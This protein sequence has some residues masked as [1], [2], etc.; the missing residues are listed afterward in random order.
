MTKVSSHS[1]H[2]VAYVLKRY[3]RYSETFVVNEIL[4]HEAAGLEI[5]IFALRPPTDPYFQPAISQV[6]APVAYLCDE[7][8]RADALWSELHQL[9]SD[10]PRTWN[11]LNACG[12]ASGIEVYQAARLARELRDRRIEHIHAHFA[13]TAA[14]VARM[15][16]LF[17]GVPYTFTAHAKDIFHESIDP[18][19][20]AQKIDGA[21]GVVTVSDFNVRFLNA[22]FSDCAPKVRRIY[23]GLD[24]AHFPFAMPLRRPAKIV[25]VGRLIEKKGFDSLIEA[26]ARL[27]Q[28]GVDFQCEIIGGGELEQA[29]RHHIDELNLDTTIHLVGPRP[30]TYV[31]KAVG[32]AA[33]LAVPSVTASTGDRDGLPMVLLEAMALGT[34]CVAT[35]V[36]GIP[37]AVRNEETG[38]LVPE[39]QPEA[40]ASAMN[41]LLVD[42]DL[43]V[44]IACTARSLVEREFDIHRNAAALRD[45]FSDCRREKVPP[46]TLAEVG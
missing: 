6:Q 42:V 46:L 8:V 2:R 21:A 30:L 45:L 16:S 31:K 22:Q 27:R 40:L 35:A 19:E 32:Q 43:C 26:C 7:H 33:I 15:S 38:L 14:T 10:F 36:T 9:G 4:A 37:E 5:Y 11:Q 28:S 34:P 13:T 3:P 17:T 24:L 18:S 20:L 1:P 23:N 29:L 12:K 39:H 44:E 41:R 25:A